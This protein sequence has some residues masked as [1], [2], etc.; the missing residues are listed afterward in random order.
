MDYIEV[1]EVLES[2]LEFWIH[3]LIKSQLSWW[4]RSKT[5]I[6]DHMKIMTVDFELR[7]DV[8]WILSYELLKM[9]DVFEW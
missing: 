2:C 7:C 6:V 3:A 8:Q 5:L 9:I 1:V 4:I